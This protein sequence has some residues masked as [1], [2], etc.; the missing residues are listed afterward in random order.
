MCGQVHK[1]EFYFVLLTTNSK[2]KIG[3]LAK[4]RGKSQYFVNKIF[5]FRLIFF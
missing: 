1:S 2:K 4:S 5:S 3:D